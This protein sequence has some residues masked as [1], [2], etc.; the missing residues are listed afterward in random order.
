MRWQGKRQQQKEARAEG[1]RALPALDPRFSHEAAEATAKLELKIK[2]TIVKLTDPDYH[3]RRQLANYAFQDFPLFIAYCEVFADVRDCLDFARKHQM[4]VVV[5][6]GGHSTAGFSINSGLV[7]DVSRLSYVV[8]DPDRKQAVVGAGARFGHLNVALDTYNLHVPGGGCHDVCVAGFLQGGGY[9][10]TSREFGINCDSVVEATVMLADGSIV[11]ASATKNPDLFWA[12]RGGTGGNFGILLQATYRLYELGDLQGFRIWWSIETPEGR[13]QAAWVLEYMQEHHTRNGTDK[14]K[15][16]YM[17]F[18]G[19]QEETP[20]LI[21][22]GM[23]DGPRDELD[24]ILAPLRR[25]APLGE[26]SAVGSYHKMDLFIHDPDL[27][28]IP[29]VPDIAR[30]DKQSGY[31]DRRLAAADWRE[32]I[33]HFLATPNPWSM[34]GIETYSDAISAQPA[35]ANAF[36][37]RAVDVDLYLDVFW[38]AE[39]EKPAAVKFLDEF[40]AFMENKYFNGQSYQNYPRAVQTD[41]RDRY[42]GDAFPTLRAVKRKYDPKDFFKYA[43]G[44]LPDAKH[45]DP[46]DPAKI[47]QRVRPWLAAPIEYQARAR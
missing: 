18:L 28:D 9:G 36:V 42:W 8:V 25:V 43:Q 22:R 20:C 38:M 47:L 26:K 14:D 21:V 40:M 17:M 11:V 44:V 4:P 45:P 46:P 30:E 12:L 16:G 6:S 23:Y 15:L 1:W 33:E 19:W 35:D 37:H 13:E 2:G 7:I 31:I 41:Y 32:V 24:R 29:Q 3:T 39:D 34:I 5:R 27:P 10:Y